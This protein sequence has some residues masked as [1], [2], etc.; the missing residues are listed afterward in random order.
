[1]EEF[2]EQGNWDSSNAV[3][4]QDTTLVIAGDWWDGNS[5]RVKK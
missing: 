4:F 2:E 1:L 5:T 3:F